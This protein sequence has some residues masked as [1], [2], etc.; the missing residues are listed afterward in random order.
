MTSLL[1]RAEPT[2]PP[3]VRSRSVAVTRAR[4]LRRRV[5]ALVVVVAV[6]AWA[7]WRA[8]PDDRPA[9]NGTAPRLLADLLTRVADP[10]LDAEF[11]ALV[12]RATATTL[13]FAALGTAAALLIGVVGGLLLSDAAWTNRLPRPVRA[14]RLGLRGVL[15]ACR[16][17]HELIWALLLVS[18]LGLDPLVAVLALAIPFGAQTAQVFGETFDTV[19]QGLYRELRRTGTPRTS[20]VAFGL[21]PVASPVLLSYSFYRFECSVRS[22]VLLG[23]VGVGGLGQELVVSLQSRNWEEVGTLVVV[24]VALSAVVEL[25]SSRVR[26]EV[27]AGRATRRSRRNTRAVARRPA[28]AAAAGHGADTEG[29]IA[30]TAPALT[31]VPPTASE[32]ATGRAGADS[33]GPGKN[34]RRSGRRP[35]TRATA[36]GLVPAL[37]LSWWAAGVSF[38]GLVD[39]TTWDLTRQL[40]FDAVPPALPDGGVSG[41]LGAVLDTLAMAVLTM[42]LAVLLSLVL[43]PWAARDRPRTTAQPA[44]ARAVRGVLRQVARL[45]LLTLR[46]IPPTVWAVL[47]LFLLYP[48][49]LPGALA[50][51]LYAGGIL[52]RLVAEAW[53]GQDDSGARALTRAGVPR[54]LAGAAAT[55]PPSFR[56]LVTYTLYRFEVS[57][58]DTTVVGVVG[59]AGLG[60]LLA[61]ALASFRFP[62]LATLLL[63]SFALSA[64]VELT[65]KR[66]RRLLSS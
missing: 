63:A 41:L 59:A 34:S 23:F 24:V 58:R 39:P 7:W 45:V 65:S 42:V 49:V 22:T 61:E 17:V 62:V 14:A 43:A 25:W 33:A 64:A 56:Q 27:A 10:R 46:S 51:G 15:V 30:A 53:E 40:L 55:V 12:G 3:G 8:V 47:A 21:V 16:S 4:V 35:W 1:D 52:G 44:V 26:A 11:L 6:V 66:V 20:A 28:A 9:V 57:I 48:G 29:L 37:L 60:R 19:D 32:P 18:V 50:L 5:T 2:V 36:W 31:P 13:A 38:A 54:W